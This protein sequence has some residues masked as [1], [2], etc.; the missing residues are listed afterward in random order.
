MR[1]VDCHNSLHYLLYAIQ[2]PR[3]WLK[4]RT[5]IGKMRYARLLRDAALFS[6]EE[7]A[8]EFALKAERHC[9]QGI[10]YTLELKDSF[11]IDYENQ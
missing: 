2:T 3:G 9:G 5:L 7:E 8:M 6:T 4:T 10:I 11:E 1:L